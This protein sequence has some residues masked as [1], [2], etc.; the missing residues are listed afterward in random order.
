MEAKL[1]GAS[2]LAGPLLAAVPLPNV[3]ALTAYHGSPHIFDKFD[4]SKIGTGE[5]AQAYGHGLYFAEDPKVAGIYRKELSA[6]QG[7]DTYDGKQPEGPQALQNAVASISVG[8]K[9]E[10]IIQEMT[11]RLAQV[12]KMDPSRWANQETRQNAIDGLRRDIDTVMGIDPAKVGRRAPGALY[13]VDIP[14]ETIDRMLDWDKP[15]SEQSAGVQNLASN[16]GLIKIVDG[17]AKMGS[18]DLGP[19]SP[20]DEVNFI[21][22]IARDG[23]TLYEAMSKAFGPE[24]VSK[25]LREAGIPGIKY[26]DGTSRTAGKGTRNFVLFDDQIPKILKRE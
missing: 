22:G 25:K 14:D 19:A 26:L 20:G 5:G 1:T 4:M 8:N 23:R 21:S 2:E 7:W 15:L 16:I 12:E 24:T 13:T 3:A 6:G 11:D 17:R 10:K 9:K 18:V